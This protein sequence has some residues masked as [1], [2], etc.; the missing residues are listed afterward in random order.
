MALPPLVP[1][2]VRSGFK[3]GLGPVVDFLIE[4]GVSPNAI[5]TFG[6]VATIIGGGIYA[7]GH[8]HLAGWVVGLSAICDMI[9]GE[10]AR[11]SGRSSVFG[12]FYD[13]T[14]D[15]VADGAIL[16][17]LALFFARN[18]VHHYI[19]DY[20][21]TPMVSVILLGILGSFLTSYTRARAEGL[22]IDAS[23]GMLQ[24]PERIVLLSA[25][26][27]FFGLAMGGWVL[28]AICVVLTVTAWITVI[29]RVLY[30]YQ[31]TN[32]HAAEGKSAQLPTFTR[33]AGGAG[34][35]LREATGRRIDGI[36]MASERMV[37]TDDADARLADVV[38][39]G[40]GAPRR[41]DAGQPSTF[42][43]AR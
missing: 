8:I 36:A 11:R 34:S 30:V 38:P 37:A 15:R 42:D 16:G 32:R 31:V 40:D 7:R 41:A 9:D 33:A 10:V 13:S 20:M 29:Q 2:L 4:R 27:A 14:L 35:E 17:G 26:Q 5:T 24:R 3:R 39:P 12:A 21:S 23:V 19:P 6:T 22:G 18:G 25:P 28:M 1:Q 43:R